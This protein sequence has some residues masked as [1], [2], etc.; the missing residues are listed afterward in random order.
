MI[1]YMGITF[2]RAEDCAKFKT[3]ERAYTQKVKNDAQKWW[4][5]LNAPVSL[6]AR[7]EC[8]EAAA[9]SQEGAQ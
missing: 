3:C 9:Q 6:T 7:R 8:Y 1:S 5:S 4:G 2:C